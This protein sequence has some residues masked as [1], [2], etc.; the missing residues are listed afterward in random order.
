MCSAGLLPAPHAATVAIAPHAIE[1]HSPAQYDFSYSVHDAHTGDVKAQHESR[2]GDVVQGEYSLIEP[3]GHRRTVTY[4]ADPHNGFNAVVQREGTVH[5]QI[6]KPVAIAAHAAPVA[7]AHQAPLTIAHQA[8]LALSHHAAPLA[9]SHQAPLAIAH[10][11]PLAYAHQ[12]PLAYAHQAPLAYAHQAPLAI[13]HQAPLAIAH[14]APLTLSHQ[15]P[16]AVAHAAPLAL[17]GATSHS[18]ITQHVRL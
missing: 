16:L 11:A 2:H 3:D 6:A 14:Q 12:A 1:H 15:A 13:A 7:V 10:Q 9:V 5:Q 18:T 8:P 17:H 4:A